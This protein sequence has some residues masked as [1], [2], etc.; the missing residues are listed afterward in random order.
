MCLSFLCVR[1]IAPC[2]FSSVVDGSQSGEDAVDTSS[3]RHWDIASYKLR[4]CSRFLG[5]LHHPAFSPVWHNVRQQAQIR[6]IYYF[7]R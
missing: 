1:A 3:S 7:D 5:R 6:I 4:V 2:L